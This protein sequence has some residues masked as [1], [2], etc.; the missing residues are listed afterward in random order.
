[1]CDNENI[2]Y[3]IQIMEYSIKSFFNSNTSFKIMPRINDKV[4]HSKIYMIVY[5]TLLLSKK[6]NK[7]KMQV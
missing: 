7:L 2:L 1:M 6:M 3:H 5:I 4:M